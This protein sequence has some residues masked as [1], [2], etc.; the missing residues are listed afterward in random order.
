MNSKEALIIVD[1][2]NDFCP[3]GNLPV[4][5]G[6]AVVKPLNKLIKY[7]RERDWTIIA[8]RDWHPATTTHFDKWPIHC[9]AQTRG[10]EFHS[11]LDLDN[12]EVFSK[13]MGAEE[14]S[15]SAFDAK[16]TED[17]SLGDFLKRKGVERIFVG[18]LATDYCVKATVLD[19]LKD[20]FKTFFID[21]A[22][23]AVNLKPGDTIAA[24]DEM[25]EAGAEAVWSWEILNGEY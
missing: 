9:V 5:D 22:S 23:R 16:N 11:A 13:G 18:G 6:D 3:G 17:L 25:F 7:A 4:P 24:L 21:D 2:Q 8:S 15:Y 1:V 12:V 20:G 14:D 10:A 19:G